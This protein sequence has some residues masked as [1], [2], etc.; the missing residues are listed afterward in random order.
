MSI[1]RDLKIY[2]EAS[3]WLRMVN[4]MAWTLTGVFI[5]LVLSCFAL[6]IKFPQWVWLYA[7]GSIFLYLVW[8]SLI[9]SYGK[10]ASKC[11]TALFSIENAWD[12]CQD[13][14]FYCNQGTPYFKKYGA[15]TIQ[16]ISF[17]IVCS[18]WFI[19]FNQLQQH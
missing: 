14:K 7:A 4:T 16:I 19:I 1:E 15:V 11:R 17:I 3:N 13:Q 5:P 18:G 2:E 12:I 10:S 9:Y 6:A 8:S